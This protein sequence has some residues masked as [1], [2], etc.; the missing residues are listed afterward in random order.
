MA[1][2][3]R[4]SHDRNSALDRNQTVS[5]ASSPAK[6]VDDTSRLEQMVVVKSS[7]VY[8]SPSAGLMSGRGPFGFSRTEDVIM[9]ALLLA[10]RKAGLEVPGPH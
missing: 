5:Y 8:S 4:C 9:G 2:V 10:E 7:F 1:S 6:Q 3:L